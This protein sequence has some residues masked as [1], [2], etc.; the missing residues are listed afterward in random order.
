MI[1]QEKSTFNTLGWTETNR[2]YRTLFTYKKAANF[3]SISTHAAET[4]RDA[5]A[6][7]AQEIRITN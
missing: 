7:F 1:R 4:N 3:S 5:S 2:K 6:I